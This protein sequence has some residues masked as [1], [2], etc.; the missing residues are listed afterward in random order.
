MLFE[1]IVL[2][3]AQD[4]E[5]VVQLLSSLREA[6]CQAAVTTSFR[7]GK[8]Q[9]EHR[10]AAILTEV[11]LGAYNGLHLA[12]LARA[13]GIPAVVLGE[14]NAATERE[15]RKIGA[16]YLT[17]S[18]LRKSDLQS[19]LRDAVRRSRAVLPFSLRARASC[20]NA[21]T[22]HGTDTFGGS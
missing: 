18:S 1:G 8:E 4:S 11:R 10:P 17:P 2:V 13:R 7:A 6:G 14:A 9:L 3:V 22:A 21:G 5:L 15:A 20:E 16:A 12:L 19:L